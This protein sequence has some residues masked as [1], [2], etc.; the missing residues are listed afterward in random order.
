MENNSLT[1]KTVSGVFWKFAERILVQ[2]I[3]FVVSVI[4]ARILM[5]ENYGTVAI[6][7][8]FVSL[9]G[10]FSDCG[11]SSALVRKKEA[12]D[13]D[14][15]TVFFSNIVLS[16]AI[17]FLLFFAAPLIA[18]FYEDKSLTALIRVVGLS[19]IVGSLKSVVSI[20]IQRKLQFRKFFFATLGGTLVSAGVAI[21]MAYA[22]FGAWALI[23]QSLINTTIDTIILWIVSGW[24]PKWK[25]SFTRFK[26]FFSYGW[27]MLCSSLLD[28]GYNDL[29][30]L[31]IGKK[32]STTDLAFYSKGQNYPNLLM[33][34]VNGSLGSVLFPAMATMQDDKPRLK[35]VVRKSMR[36]S[37]YVVFPLMMGLACVADNFVSVVLTDKWLPC[38]PFLQ[39]ACFTYALM[40][41]HTA[42]LHAISAMGRSDVFLKLEIIKK[43][44]GLTVIAI[45]MWFGVFWM[46]MSTILTS[47]LSSVINA[48]PNKK[49]LDYGYPEQIKDLLPNLLI[50]VLMGIPVYFLGWLPL[51][52]WIVLIIQVVA[53]IAIYVLLSIVTKN[54]SFSFVWGMIKKFLQGRKKREEGKEKK[55]E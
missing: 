41:I 8:V 54:E 53:G 45:S 17:Y 23:A 27:K 20:S 21:W 25:F 2:I 14:Y 46:A 18:S 35:S 37:A 10:V 5:P 11:L 33:S 30:T 7:N 38:V 32:Y 22:G 6:I 12:D 52:K 13:V 50:A 39:I 26:Q 29:R 55:T 4:L 9:F 36:T 15:S 43:A 51:A 28:V 40:P 3:S 49:L 1:Q 44:V 47:I 48:F 24:Q 34:S 31:I 42:N 16:T 19:I